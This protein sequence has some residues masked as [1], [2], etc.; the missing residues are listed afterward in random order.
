MGRALNGH[1]DERD[2]RIRR[3]FAPP[4]SHIAFLLDTLF[5]VFILFLLL[6]A[7]V[8]VTFVTTAAATTSSSSTSAAATGRRYGFGWW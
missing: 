4:H 3:F 1:H 7:F 6:V 8:V 2:V 5:H